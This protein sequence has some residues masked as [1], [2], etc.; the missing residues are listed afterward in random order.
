MFVIC[1]CVRAREAC[2]VP[3]T[4]Q[5]R[6]AGRVA[7]SEDEEEIKQSKCG[8]LRYRCALAGRAEPAAPPPQPLPTES[9]L[10]AVLSGFKGPQRGGGDCVQVAYLEAHSKALQGFQV[11]YHQAV[12]GLAGKCSHKQF[13]I[14]TWPHILRRLASSNTEASTLSTERLSSAMASRV[15]SKQEHSLQIRRR[16]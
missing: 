6:G 10:G 5:A 15:R 11:A 1:V 14:L 8:G 12:W 2:P 13:Q 4:F 3:A 7:L 9:Q 16:A